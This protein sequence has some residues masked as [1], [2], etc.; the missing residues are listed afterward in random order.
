M[1]NRR[2][3]L[4]GV[5]TGVV[6]ATGLIATGGRA[7]TPPLAGRNTSGMTPSQLAAF[8]RRY[9]DA[10]NTRD[11][12]A[13]ADMVHEDV[14]QNGVAHKRADVLASFH[15]IV[16]A[17]PDYHW[18]L[19]QLVVQGDLIAARFQNT[20]TPVKEFFGYQATGRSLNFMEF[21][22]YRV[23]DGRFADMWF[24]EDRELIAKQ[25]RGEQA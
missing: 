25:L 1:N 21:C 3:I 13:V 5:A 7:A 9:I 2:E 14:F 15:S 20:G 23:R 4:T 6:A 24:M 10:I 8:Y 16:D 22:Q 17:C 11:L 19:Q 18:G 12:D